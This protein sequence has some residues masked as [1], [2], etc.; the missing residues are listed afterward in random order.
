MTEH[1]VDTLKLIGVTVL[2]IAG[3]W[4]GYKAYEWL[5]LKAIKRDVMSIIKKGEQ[6]AD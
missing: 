3:S 1:E 6:N 2:F 4:A 5:R